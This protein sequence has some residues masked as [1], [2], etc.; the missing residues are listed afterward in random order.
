[1]D[2]DRILFMFKDGS[3]AWEARD[4]LIKQSTCKEVV[5]EGQ[6]TKG[7]GSTLQE[8]QEL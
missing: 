5:L 2:D 6:T 8:Q 7:L 4:F 3:Q 1:M